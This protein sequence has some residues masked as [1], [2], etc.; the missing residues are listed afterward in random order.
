MVNCLNYLFLSRLFNPK[1][2]IR[3]II[4]VFRVQVLEYAVLINQEE[5]AILVILFMRAPSA[6]H[7]LQN[8]QAICTGV[9]VTLSAVVLVPLG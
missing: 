9:R 2:V 1:S 8:L 3:V 7:F 4:Q 5:S 6:I